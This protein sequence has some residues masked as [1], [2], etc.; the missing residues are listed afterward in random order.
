MT[1][2][3]SAEETFEKYPIIQRKPYADH[4]TTFLTPKGPDG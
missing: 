4:L 3:I 1:E 2:I